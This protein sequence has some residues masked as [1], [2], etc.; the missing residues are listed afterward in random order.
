MRLHPFSLMGIQAV[1]CCKWVPFLH[2]GTL[3]V[4]FWTH[5]DSV[6]LTCEDADPGCSSSAEGRCVWWREEGRPIQQEKL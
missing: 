2:L 4:G 3:S 1:R 6:M 5:K